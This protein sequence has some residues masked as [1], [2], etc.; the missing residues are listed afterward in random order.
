MQHAWRLPGAVGASMRSMPH[1]MAHTQVLR[2]VWCLFE[3]FKTVAN[4]GVR[5][6]VVLAH[7]VRLN[8]V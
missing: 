5:D 1:D 2:R 7:E 3:I 4:K 8:C 6:L